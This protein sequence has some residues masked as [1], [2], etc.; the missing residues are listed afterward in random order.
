MTKPD[1]WAAS[2]ELAGELIN[3]IGL[4]Q[5]ITSDGDGPQASSLPFEALGGE[6][7]KQ[8]VFHIPRHVP[9]NRALEAGCRALVV[10]TGAQGYVSPS[11]YDEPDAPTWNFETVQVRGV[12]EL[13]SEEETWD[14]LK[15]LNERHERD[16]DNPFNLGEIED[17]A[18]LDTMLAA[19]NGF[20]IPMTDVTVRQKLSQNRTPGE[21]NAICD[22]LLA[23]RRPLDG[24]LSERMLEQITA[25]Q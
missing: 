21:Q 13:L 16:A 1:R 9:Q 18:Y 15:R 10:F 17:T 4:G 23:R 19:I 8:L 12:P 25:D 6:G 14:H 3:S 24:W 7:S 20:S 2:P 5:L 11:W 22:G